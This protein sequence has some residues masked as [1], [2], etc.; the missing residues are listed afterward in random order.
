MGLRGQRAPSEGAGTPQQF[1]PMF[2]Y[3]PR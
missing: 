1:R 3:G 2:H